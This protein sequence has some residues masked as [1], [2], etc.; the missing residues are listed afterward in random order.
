MAQAVELL[1]CILE[2]PI[3]NISRNIACYPLFFF[4]FKANGINVPCSTPRHITT[5]SFPVFHSIAILPFDDIGHSPSYCQNHKMITLNTV[6]RKFRFICSVLP[7]QIY[8][9]IFLYPRDDFCW[10]IFYCYFHYAL[11]LVSTSLFRYSFMYTQRAPSSSCHMGHVAFCF[12]PLF[13]L[14]C[15]P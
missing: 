15:Q 8:I 1:T 7:P 2:V 11:H 12:P 13:P 9:N 5:T 4:F 10:Y 3:S 6:F 14:I